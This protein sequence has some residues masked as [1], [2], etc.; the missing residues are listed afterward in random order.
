[1]AFG[2]FD[3][4]MCKGQQYEVIL[5]TW[6]EDG[7][8]N[9]APFGTIVKSNYEI[10]NRIFEG[11]RTLENIKRNGEFTVNLTYNPLYFSYSLIYSFIAPEE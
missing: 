9:S 10:V 11:S 1:M 3:I 2:L 7:S 5:T 8:R 6:N 4:G